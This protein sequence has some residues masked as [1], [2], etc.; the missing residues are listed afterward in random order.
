MFVFQIP[1]PK[2]PPPEMNFIPSPSNTDFV[3]L[4]GLEHVVDYLTNEDRYVYSVPSE[5][6]EVTNF[7]CNGVGFT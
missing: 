6:T 3:Y 4:V 5:P 1:P 7:Q 2:P